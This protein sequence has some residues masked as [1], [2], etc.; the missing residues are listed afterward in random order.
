MHGVVAGQ[1]QPR[2]DGLRR[3]LR[4]DAVF[5]QRVA[6]DAVVRFGI[7]PVFVDADA[8]AP[9]IALLDGVAETRHDVSLAIAVDV[10]QG[11]QKASR[12]RRVV[13]VIGAAPGVDV[14]H[15]VRS[16]HHVARVADMVG[17]YGGAKSL[18]QSDPAIVAGASLCRCLAGCLALDRRG[19]WAA[20][21]QQDC[22]SR[23]AQQNRAEKTSHD[24]EPRFAI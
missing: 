22:C 6:D 3:A 11:D 16:H 14:D 18:G 17:E 10:L 5:R 2:D 23:C 15:A 19:K 1:R 8:G 9:M 21:Q 4:H 13:A 12:R 20:R 7:K 24:L